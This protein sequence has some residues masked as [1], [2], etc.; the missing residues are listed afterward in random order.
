MPTNC[1]DVHVYDDAFSFSVIVF[2][3]LYTL[4]VVFC[5]ILFYRQY[6]VNDTRPATKKLVEPG[7]RWPSPT[8]KMLARH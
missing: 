7:K 8:E 5:R 6:S 3:Q 1:M 4:S 2:Y